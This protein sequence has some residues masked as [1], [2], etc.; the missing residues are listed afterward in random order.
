[1]FVVYRIVMLFSFIEWQESFKHRYYG[2]LLWGLKPNLS[3]QIQPWPVVSSREFQPL[4][5][6]FVHSQPLPTHL[7]HH[8]LPGPVLRWSCSTDYPLPTIA[9]LSVGTA[10]QSFLNSCR[11]PHQLAYVPCKTNLSTCLSLFLWPQLKLL[12]G[13]KSTWRWQLQ[14][15]SRQRNRN[16][17]VT[18]SSQ[19][20]PYAV[21][22]TGR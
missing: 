15:L 2:L 8:H 9:V 11:I 1:M 7:S 16:V 20:S 12:C 14:A 18:V 22:S 5:P 10:T 4:S 3:N 21:E 19:H 17:N 13:A 6:E